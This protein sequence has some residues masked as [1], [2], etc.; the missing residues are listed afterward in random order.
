MGLFDWF[1]GEKSR[2]PTARR[3]AARAMVLSTIVCR[4]YLE[5][6]H[7][8]GIHENAE[9]RSGLLYWLEEAGLESELEPEELKFLET[10]VGQASAQVAA[11]AIWRTEGLGVLA[12]SFQ[13]Y[14]LPPYDETTN[15]DVAQPAVGFLAPIEEQDL[16]KSGVLRPAPEIHRLAS[17]VTIVSWRIRQF[18]VNPERLSPS[19]EFEVGGDHPVPVEGSVEMRKIAG[20]GIGERMDLVAYLRAHP[21]FQEYWLDN[22][23]LIDNDLAI[24]DKSIADAAPDEVDK[25]R[26][27]AVERQIAAYWLEADERIYSKVNPTTLL[28]GC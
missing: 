18:R 21:R 2:R 13:R 28:S 24:G 7:H 11:N 10:P 15:P 12:W 1:F 6:E 22:L 5:R 8:A 26:S 14:E 20:P 17:H 23:R 9:G 27:I 25:C 16:R 19:I 3:V 4:A